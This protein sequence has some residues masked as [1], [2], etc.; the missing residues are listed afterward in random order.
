[1]SME[2][3]HRSLPAWIKGSYD[4]LRGASSS[5][6]GQDNTLSSVEYELM[7]LRRAVTSVQLEKKLLPRAPLPKPDPGA[8]ASKLRRPENQRDPHW[9]AVLGLDR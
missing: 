3:K 2:L 6:E 1:M 4:F 7:Q 9:W 8:F 5:L